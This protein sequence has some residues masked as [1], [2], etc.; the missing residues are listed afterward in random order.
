MAASTATKLPQKEQVGRRDLGLGI[1]VWFL[2]Q[3]IAY[4]FNSV[5][6]KWAFLTQPAGGITVLQWVELVITLIALAAMAYLIYRPWQAWRRIEAR[7]PVTDRH[8]IGR[9]EDDRGGFMAFVAMGLNGFLLLFVIFSI[10]P[11][12]ALKACG[13][14]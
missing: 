9:T 4:Q 14:A 12:L 1:L 7:R 5:A 11:V 13:Q 8:L 2:H 3:N 10:V 6:C